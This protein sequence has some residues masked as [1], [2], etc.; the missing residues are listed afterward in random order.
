[1]ALENMVG[2]LKKAALEKSAVGAFN[3]LDYNSMRAVIKAAEELSMAVIVQTSPATVKYWGVNAIAGWM[4]ELAVNLSVPAALHLDHC[5]DLELIRKCIESGWSS[6]MI[7]ASSKTFAENT[8]LTKEVVVMAHPKGI[9]VEAEIGRIG[10]VEDAFAVKEKDAN[11]ADPAEAE[12]FCEQTGIDCLAPAIGTAH[13]FYKE[14]PKIAFERIKKIA[15]RV[16]LPLALH[17]G[18][19]LSAEVFRRCIRCGCAKINVSTHIKQAFIC[20]FTDYY[21][22]HLNEND[23]LKVINAQS[24]RI[25]CEVEKFMNVFKNSAIGNPKLKI[26]NGLRAWPALGE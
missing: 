8:A 2:M 19:G 3:I 1:M 21:G 9:S 12:R 24:E 7:D 14:T 10:G 18:T 5:K 15:R 11:L 22:E 13:G 16:N 26:E 20:G 25:K 17:G 23:P 6:V 4:R